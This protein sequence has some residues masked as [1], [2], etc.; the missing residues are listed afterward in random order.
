MTLCSSKGIVFNASKFQFGAKTVNFL[1]FTVTEDSV[2]PSDKYLAAIRDFPTP[3]D[4]T[5]VRSW[6]GLVNQVNYAFSNS[7]AMLPFRHLLKPDEAFVWTD[8]LEEA[9]KKSKESIL[10][11][12]KN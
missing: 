7:E 8:T 4:M 5:G 9:F 6:Y 1:G 3:T 11:A 10:E 2:K 12:V